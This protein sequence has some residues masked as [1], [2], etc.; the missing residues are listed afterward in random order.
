MCACVALSKLINEGMIACNDGR[1]HE[2]ALLLDEALG[3]AERLGSPVH[4]A[5]IR[6]NLGLVFQLQGRREDARQAF[7]Q[8]LAGVEKRVGRCNRLYDSIQSNLRRLDA[9]A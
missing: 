7:S 1:Y 5:K 6:N 3:Q 8:A 4:Q 2:A 9:A